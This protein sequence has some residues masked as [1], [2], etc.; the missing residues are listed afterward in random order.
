[1]GAAAFAVEN[2][3]RFG[4]ATDLEP[5]IANMEK[6]LAPAILAAASLEMS[7]AK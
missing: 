6:V 5:L 1:L 4:D 3:I 2:A 7:V